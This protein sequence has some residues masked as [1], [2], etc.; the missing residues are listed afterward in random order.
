MGTSKEGVLLF[1]STL[2]IRAFQGPRE[3][4][5][6]L[7]TVRVAPISKAARMWAL[8]QVQQQLDSVVLGG[9]GKK[10]GETYPGLVQHVHER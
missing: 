6:K 5:G 9:A 3:A 10:Q 1:D 8:A 2:D 4:P 7:G